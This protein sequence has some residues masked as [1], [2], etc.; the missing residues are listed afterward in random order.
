MILPEH[1]SDLYNH[2]AHWQVLLDIL[3]FAL[4]VFYL[5][6]TLR[7][8]G[9]WK[10]AVGLIVAGVVA[11]IATM[12]GL[13][14]VEWI[15]SNLSQFALIVLIVIFQPEL[16]KIL[17]RTTTLLRNQT[18]ADLHSLPNLIEETL[19]ELAGRKWGAIIVLPGNDP[20]QQWI[21]EGVKVD[22]IPSLPML[23]SIFDPN[24]PGHDGALIM[25]QNRI[26]RIG[27][28]LPLSESK[29]LSDA[30]GTRHHAS[31][32]LA[33]KT[34]SLVLTVSEERGKISIFR[35]GEMVPV[36]EKGEVAAHILAHSKNSGSN[37]SIIGLGAGKKFLPLLLEIGASLM[38]ATLFWT[39]VIMSKIET[40]EM[41]FTVP[42]QYTGLQENL[43]LDRDIPSEVKLYLEGSSS[44]LSTMDLS[45]LRVQVNLNEVTE[46]DQVVAL[47]GQN[48]VVPRRVKVT[49]INPSSIKISVK[50]LHEATLLIKP[51]LLGKVQ[52]GM[53]IESVNVIP[54]SIQVLM[55]K[56]GASFQVPGSLL[57]TP[58]YLHGIKENATVYCKVIVPGG[59]QSP[60]RR[61]P[62]VEV[63]IQVKPQ[64]N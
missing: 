20:I 50:A 63:R 38:V 42:I 58:I 19:F 41:I 11:M 25:E 18:Q 34:D 4:A 10:I 49:D 57:T 23:V 17:E 7:A 21:T 32:G 14:G 28:H 47:T 33:E 48:V 59:V 16:R 62:D 46:G 8:S 3:I 5:S 13:R 15:F 27:V 6:R 9:T 44:L 37:L 56:K 64:K 12:I 22:A 24:S 36:R 35:D 29:K 55:P 30:F 1:F 40:R 60:D 45:Q 51:Q 39:L 53:M 31:L 26:S 52:E 54:P 2:L 43:V 61:W